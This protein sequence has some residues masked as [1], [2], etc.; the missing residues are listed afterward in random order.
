MAKEIPRFFVNQKNFLIFLFAHGIFHKYKG[1]PAIRNK[2]DFW[3]EKSMAIYFHPN[4]FPLHPPVCCQ[5]NKFSEHV[6]AKWGSGVT[7]GGRMSPFHE[8]V[9]KLR[10]LLI[11]SRPSIFPLS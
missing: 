4:V 2:Y 7:G 9:K 6:A 10:T 5:R 3:T 1:L 8:R 11:S